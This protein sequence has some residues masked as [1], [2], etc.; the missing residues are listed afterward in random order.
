V[1]VRADLVNF[2]VVDPSPEK[3][4]T[5]L[6]DPKGEK[7]TAGSKHPAEPLR[8]APVFARPDPPQAVRPSEEAARDARKMVAFR[9]RTT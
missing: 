9:W 8:A 4:V 1:I 3:P 7:S 5:R 2:K 6:A